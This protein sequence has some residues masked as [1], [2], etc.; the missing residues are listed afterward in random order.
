MF[1]NLFVAV[2]IEGFESSNDAEGLPIAEYD[3]EIFREFWKEYD[4]QGLGFIKIYDLENLILDLLQS[5]TSLLPFKNYFI[6]EEKARKKFIAHL[7]IPTYNSFQDYY[8]FDILVALCRETCKIQYISNK[9]AMQKE[10]LKKKQRKDKKLASMN[11]NVRTDN[12]EEEDN[13]EDDAED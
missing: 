9:V 11:S 3:L 4:P 1:L 8:Y 13:D 6:N 2:V 5:D 7:C 10:K 12:E